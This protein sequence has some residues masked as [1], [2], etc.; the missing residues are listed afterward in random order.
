MLAS[1]LRGSFLAHVIP[2]GWLRLSVTAN[3]GY[4][5]FGV[6]R[7]AVTVWSDRDEIPWR[8]IN[9]FGGTLLLL[10]DVHEKGF[11]VDPTSDR[12]LVRASGSE[13]CVR[14]R[15]LLAAGSLAC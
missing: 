3:V 6:E 2:G 7:N 14:E 8:T 10:N 9:G 15:M 4:C 12:G 5:G 13:G 11:S 1:R